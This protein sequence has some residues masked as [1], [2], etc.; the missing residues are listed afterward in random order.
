MILYLRP[1][2]VHLDAAR[3]AH[4][5]FPSRFYSQDSS[6]PSHVTVRRPFEHITETGSLGHPERATAD[7]GQAILEVA[8]EQVVACVR[9]IAAWPPL[10]P[11]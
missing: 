7:K 11:A 8:V 3:G 1:E 5:P 10:E 9:E 6:R 2:L 4:T